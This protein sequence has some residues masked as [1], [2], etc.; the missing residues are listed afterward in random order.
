MEPL[1]IPTMTGTILE[2]SKGTFTTDDGQEVTYSNAIVRLGDR[3]FKLKVAP[4]L[5]LKEF[6]G[7]DVKIRMSLSPR[8]QL[9]TLTVVDCAE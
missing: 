4:G 5:N 2:T 3:E 1:L 9:P 7:K 6:E 8:K